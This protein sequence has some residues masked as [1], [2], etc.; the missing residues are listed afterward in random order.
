MNVFNR[1]KK[2]STIVLKKNLIFID[3]NRCVEKEDFQRQLL[4]KLAFHKIMLKMVVSD[5]DRF[6]GKYVRMFYPDWSLNIG[7]Y[8]A[9]YC[10]YKNEVKRD[11]SLFSELC[12]I[13]WSFGFHMDEGLMEPFYSKFFENYTLIN[14]M[15]DH[16]YTWKFLT[17]GDNIV[18]IQV[19]QYPP[20]T[21]FRKPNGQWRLQNEYVFFDQT[22]SINA[23]ELP[24]L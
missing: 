14:G 19:D 24:L 18:R 7:Y 15:N 21:S 20:L 11:S 3:I 8:K 2:L 10:I 22:E 16:I 9:S 6:R 23:E 4:V 17:C 5:D 12:L 13:D 1:I